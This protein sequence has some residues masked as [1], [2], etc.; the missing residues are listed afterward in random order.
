MLGGGRSPKVGVG[1]FLFHFPFTSG[2]TGEL[3]RVESSSS[4]TRLGS[5]VTGLAGLCDW[6]KG[7]F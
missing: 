6:K 5:P 7:R 3:E 4:L 2:H 1:R